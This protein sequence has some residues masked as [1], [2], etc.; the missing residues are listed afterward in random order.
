MRC[1]IGLVPFAAVASLAAGA[2]AQAPLPAVSVAPVA[3]AEVAPG[4]EFVGRVEA[5]NAVDIRARV[6]GFI[7]ARPFAEGQTVREWQELFV[8]ERD[9]YDAALSAARASLAAA[10]ASLRDAEGRLQR[11]QEL[12]RTQ[13]VSQAAVEEIQAARDTA[14]ANV[15]SA[16]AGVRQAELNLGH[17]VIRAPIAGRIGAAAFAVGSLVGPSSGA[18]AR[19]VQVHPIRVVFS[20]GDRAI[21]DLREGAGGATKEDLAQKYVP[22][23]RLSNGREFPAKGEIEFAGNEID[24]ATGTLPV[25]ARF[26]NPDALLVPGQ[27]V[28]VVIRPSDPQRRP[29]VPV[30]AVQLDRE[31]RFVLVLDSDNRVA[32]RRVRTGT[33]IG[34]SWTVEEGLGGGET[35]VVQGLQNVRPGEPV[36]VVPVQGAEAPA[37][38]TGAV[39]R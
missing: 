13:A 32:K 33:Q 8:I 6:D 5:V 19:V 23:L 27:F 3:I 4:S 31:G 20:V 37:S 36:R 14:Q 16:E 2:A 10:Q 12:R 18:L 7:E 34:Q 22:T 38:I 25:W 29:I 39:A 24:P 26:P 9:A 21:L 30:G 15:M 35:L 11:N 17:T 1:V 28:T